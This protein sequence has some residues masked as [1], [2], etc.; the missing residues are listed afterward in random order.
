MHTLILILLL[1]IIIMIMMLSVHKTWS[2][3]LRRIAVHIDLSDQ[4]ACVCVCQ[5]CSNYVCSCRSMSSP[6][7]NPQGYSTLFKWVSSHWRLWVWGSLGSFP[8]ISGLQ[9]AEQPFHPPWFPQD[10]H[11]ARLTSSWIGCRA[12]VSL[13][14]CLSAPIPCIIKAEYYTQRQPSYRNSSFKSISLGIPNPSFKTNTGTI[15]QCVLLFLH[16]LHQNILLFSTA[17]VSATSRATQNQLLYNGILPA[18]DAEWKCRLPCKQHGTSFFWIPCR[19]MR[20]D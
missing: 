3:H 13:L 17:D 14:E 2:K 6:L 18:R 20:L 9:M 11:L 1:L 4:C 5:H 10:G 15:L 19:R 16:A 7:I 12:P 8:G